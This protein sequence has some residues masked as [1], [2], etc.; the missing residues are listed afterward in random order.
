MGYTVNRVDGATRDAEF[1]A[2]ARLLRQQGVDLGKLPR[3]PEP[4]TRRRWLYVW[5]TRDKAQLFADEL[6]KITD[7]DSWN[8]VEV[9]APASEGPMGPLII[10][11]GRRADGLVFG[12]H[13]LSRAL[14][15][16]AFPNVH[17]TANTVSIGFETLADFNV[18][19][20]SMEDLAREVVPTLTGLSSQQLGMLGYSV[21]EDDTGD[22]LVY[23]PPGDLI[24]S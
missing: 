16:S 13:P 21:I 6:R 23:V 7:D 18:N 5:D 11:A 24:H 2:Y 10:Q 20:G 15:Q 9:A 4:N 3:A 8:V 12:L 17:A 14:V 19:H 22:T 1:E